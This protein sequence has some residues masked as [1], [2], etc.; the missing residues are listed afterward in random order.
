MKKLYLLTTILLLGFL[1]SSIIWG[2]SRLRINRYFSTREK[3]AENNKIDFIHSFKVENRINK[4]EKGA[5]V[6]FFANLEYEEDILTLYEMDQQYHEDLDVYWLY[7]CSP[8]KLVNFT[9]RHPAISIDWL[10]DEHDIL[11]RALDRSSYVLDSNGKVALR[12]YSVPGKTLSDTIDLLVGQ[13]PVVDGVAP[14]RNR[15]TLIE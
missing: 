1:L 2:A 6:I 10:F 5:T 3:L 4:P 8:N 12:F 11:F 9:A 14:D 7:S 13:I 15:I